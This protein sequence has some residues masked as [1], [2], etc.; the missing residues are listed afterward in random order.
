[1]EAQELQ[2]GLDQFFGTEKWYRHFTGMLYTDGIKYLAEQAGAYWL[3]DAVGSYQPVLQDE[4]FQLWRLEVDLEKS[5]GVLTMRRDTGLKPLVT[6][7]IP[8]T[9]FPLSEYEWYVEYNVM[10][11][12]NEH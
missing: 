8:Y 11:L 12:K 9:D 1:M 5:T 3:I 10:L 2:S 4:E 6:Q 7:K